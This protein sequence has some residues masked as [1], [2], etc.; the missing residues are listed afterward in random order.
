MEQA[1][2]RPRADGVASPGSIDAY[3]RHIEVHG[4]HNAK[5][6]LG[7]SLRQTSGMMTALKSKSGLCASAAAA[8]HRD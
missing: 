7:E 1:G 8:K 6:Q 2:Y 3:R 5:A 4:F